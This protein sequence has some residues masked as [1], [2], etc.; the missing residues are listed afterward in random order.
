MAPGAAN[1]N[2]FSAACLILGFTDRLDEN[3]ERAADQR[4]VLLERDAL[5]ELHD[6]VASLNRNL[7]WNR[8]LERGGLGAVL[9]RVW[10][11]ADM[12]E[13]RFLDESP[14]R[15]ELLLRLAG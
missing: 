1:R 12:V 13:L 10:E 15:L 2:R 7:W 4:L 9:G 5:L 6:D 3:I 8:L 11:D 14:Q